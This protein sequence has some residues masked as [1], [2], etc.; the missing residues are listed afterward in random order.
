MTIYTSETY[1]SLYCVY[2]TIYRGNKLP[3]F[4]IGS[5]SLAK[6]STGYHGSV[7]SKEYGKIWKQE[8]R[9]N[10][11]QFKTIIL[12]EH[13]TRAAA[14]DHEEYLQKARKVVINPMYI[15]RSYA[16]AKFT[17]KQH[18]SWTRTNLKG[19]VAWNKGLKLT[20][21]FY[22]KGGRKNKGKVKGPLSPAHKD[23][24]KGPNSSKANS[25]AKNGMYGK[26]H[27]DEI[28][29]AQGK[30]ATDRFKGK[31]YE[32][33]YGKEKADEL[34]KKRSANFKGKDNAGK[35]N[36]RARR[37]LI[38]DPSG[39]E[40]ECFGN[41]RHTCKELG[42]PFHLIYGVLRDGAT[43]EHPKIKGYSA[44]YVS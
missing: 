6:V 40:I 27:T 41:L 36:P 21:E 29:A 10:P 16:N 9:D 23:K 19:R 38:V 1:R 5:T 20:D 24:L 14:F 37:I 33:L 17:L 26:T 32:E 34:K 8:L 18:T 35:N 7:S 31:S 11:D 42:L 44:T 3:P 28:K 43:S 15:N 4:Y 13:S 39:K 30:V 12:S 22:K 25:G 2:L